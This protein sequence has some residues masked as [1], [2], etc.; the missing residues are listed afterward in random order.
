MAVAVLSVCLAHL[1]TLLSQVRWWWGLWRSWRGPSP[2]SPGL[3]SFSIPCWLVVMMRAVVEVA[4]GEEGSISTS[5]H[6]AGTGKR[7]LNIKIYC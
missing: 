5:L 6:R 7:Y 4:V 3:E 1:L 2:S